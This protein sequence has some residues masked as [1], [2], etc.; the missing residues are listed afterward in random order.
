[1][2]KKSIFI[3]LVLY[4]LFSCNN[5]NQ[6]STKIIEPVVMENEISDAQR[7]VDEIFILLTYSL[8]YK[9]WQSIDIPRHQR[10]G[11]NIGAVLV[12][13]E[14]KAVAFDLNAINSTDNSTQHGEVR[15]IT[16]FLEKEKC[17]NLDGYTIYTTLEPCIMCAGMI[18]MTDIDRAVFGQKD[19][20][21]SKAFERLAIDTTPIGGFPP[22]PRKVITFSSK[23]DFSKEL[24]QAFE[25][26]LEKDDEKFLAKFLA[27]DKAKNIFEKASRYFLKYKVEFPENQSVYDETI[28]FFNHINNG[29]GKEN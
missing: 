23:L 8:V 17:F 27:S 14:N 26:F 4:L 9:D 29:D 20:Q 19:V 6:L 12:N 16:K 5:T 1:M 21:Y 13:K 28:Q 18:T 24:N 25:E 22:Y 3:G 2:M 7:E 11:Y 10:R 15:V